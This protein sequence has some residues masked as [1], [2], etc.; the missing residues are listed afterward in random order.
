MAAR[1]PESVAKR[2]GGEEG[3]IGREALPDGPRLRPMRAADLD[4]VLAIERSSF[5][6]PWKERTFRGLLRRKDAELWVAELAG[7]GVVGYLVLWFATD[8]GE[9]ADLA[10]AEEQRGRGIGSLLLGRAIDLARDRGVGSLFLEVRSSNRRAAELYRERGFQ[11]VTVREDYYRK[12][13]EDALVM[14]KSLW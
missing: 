10:V 5:T 7:A 11:V 6:N 12:P 13:T 1:V 9:L 8:E 14:F 3:G 2:T 4:R